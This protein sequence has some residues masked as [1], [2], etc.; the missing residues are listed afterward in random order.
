MMSHNRRTPASRR[1]LLAAVLLL[2]VALPVRAEDKKPDSSLG[3]IP[4]DAAFYSAMLRN[5]EQIDAV[6]N[7]KTW[8]RITELPFYQMAVQQ[9]KK[10]YE[11]G[12]D[13]YLAAFRQ[14]L[15]Q[16]ENQDLVQM[17]KDAVSTEIF[18]YA[19]G[20]WVDFVDL[21]QQMYGGNSY[22]PFRQWLKD[23]QLKNQK[24]MQNASVRELL[25]ALAR[26]PNKIK[27]PDFVVGFKIKNAKKAKAQIDRLETLLQALAG[28]Q[29]ML[30]DR[31]KRV[32]VGD[33]SFLTMS[34]DGNMIPWDEID[35]KDVEEAA[36]EF[37]GVRKNLK[38][39]KLTIS[40]GVR[41]DFLLFSI[42]ST[43]DG[44][45]QLGGEGPRLT[46]RPELKPLVR[47][48]NKRL[49]GI[50]YSSKALAAI[51]QTK[52]EDIDKLATMA[53]QALDAAG[54][55]ENKRKAIVKDVSGLA[56]DL[57]KELTAP[58]A[59]L[60]FSYL[61]KRGYEGF[62]YHYGEFPDRDSSKALTLLD[63][64]GGDPIL[65][66]VG[67]SR[68]TLERYQT[69]SKWIKVAY[70]HAEPLILEKLS[71][72][73]KQKYEEATKQIFPLLKRCDAITGK[74]LLPSLADDQ[75]GFVLDAKWKSKQWHPAMPAGDKPLPMPEL[76]LLVGVSDRALLEKA[77]KSY[78]KLIEEALE[79]VKQNAPPDSQPPFT[80]LPE[81]EVKEVTAGKLYQWRLPKEAQLDP[82]VAL[83]AGL[84]EKV[85]VVS[86][87]AGHAER[88][89]KA[90]PLKVEGG[91]LADT[92]RALTEASYFNW[93]A[94]IDMLSPWVM[95]ALEQAPLDK[96]LPGVSAAGG[97]EKPDKKG[98]QNKQRAEI[99]RHVRVVLDALKAIRISTS[100]TYIEEG[101]LITHSELVIRDE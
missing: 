64:V 12:N 52:A 90:K 25:R 20:N 85:G 39:L 48:A 6:A 72:Q 101:A 46:S 71:D 35:W 3:L 19:A 56:R 15:A 5:R 41:D 88:L 98:G 30:Q 68:G 21:V 22:G 9:F 55:P 84:S 40:L 2:A 29:P 69:V 53:E 79:L 42:G 44:I 75:A 50:S 96:A 36:G 34:F 16:E 11:E 17:L 38:K 27:V 43:T 80:K 82:R 37:D 78:G 67:R 10:Q 62:D 92:K 66:V 76:A 18:C 4:A 8:A 89:L 100:A 87:S 33:S 47:A 32:K 24:A 65:A 57:K 63:H 73:E 14:W 93:P 58:G 54:I 70:G 13:P 95:F 31:V 99:I 45:K 86:L 59:S 1:G 83:S 77:M 91:P 26:N 7:S 81:P 23:P 60:S 61:S 51:S 28:F 94:F 49:T 74:M 97:E